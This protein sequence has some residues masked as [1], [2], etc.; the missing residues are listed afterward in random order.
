MQL[1]S[2]LLELKIS[3]GELN[4]VL[5]EAKAFIENSLDLD[6]FFDQVNKILFGIKTFKFTG[7]FPILVYE[8][9]YACLRKPRYP[10][11]IIDQCASLLP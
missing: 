10:Y 5:R 11:Y 9:I 2:L 6:K 7:R 1:V 4:G 8:R 3:T